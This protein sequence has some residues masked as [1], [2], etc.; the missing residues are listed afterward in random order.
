MRDQSL[1]Q[2]PDLGVL[3]PRRSISRSAWSWP[4]TSPNA[5]PARLSIP[6]ATHAPLVL[7]GAAIPRQ[8]GY[9]HIIE[10]WQS[11]WRDAFREKGY[12]RLD[13]IR[14]QVRDDPQVHFWFKQNVSL[15]VQDRQRDLR[16]VCHLRSKRMAT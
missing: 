2:F 4:N 11:Y 10:R 6:C 14:P 13:F 16:R 5:R 1:A 7:F 15:Y 9:R 12:S 3:N 8:D